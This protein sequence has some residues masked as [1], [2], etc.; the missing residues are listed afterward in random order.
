MS[1]TLIWYMLLPLIL[2]GVIWWVAGHCM[3]ALKAVA[4]YAVTAMIVA[5]IGFGVSYGGA[6]ADTEIWNGQVT[7]KYVK[8]DDYKR[9]YDCNCKSVESCSGFGS[10]RRCSTSRVCDT[11][12]E[13]R[14]TKKWWCDTT[15]GSFTIQSLDTTSK[16]VWYTPDPGR[17]TIIKPG[18]PAS[19]T[20]MYTN[21]VQAVPGSLFRPSSEALKQRF[22]N[23]IPAYPDQIYDFY[24]VNRF[25]TPGYNVT[26]AAQWNDAIG[27]L[28]KVRGPQKQVNVVVVV[29]KTDDQNYVHALR[30]AWQGA[31]KNDVVLVIGSATWPKIDFVDIISWTKSEIFK[32]QLRDDVM[33]L[34]TVAQEPIIKAL[35]SNIDSTYVRREMSEFEYLKGEI[36]PPTWLLLMMAIANFLFAGLMIAHYKGVNLMFWKKKK[37]SW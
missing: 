6:V 4:I 10:N 14:Y 23:L 32:V 18:D 22:V 31:N 35:A 25:L 28:L 29:A 30:D 37:L 1:D 13:D 15:V 34:G 36:D 27:H 24:R 8:T 33:A 19:R 7:A 21:Y 17:W 16:S 26:E 12:Y 3:D 9:P 11:C 2:G 5:G 20:S